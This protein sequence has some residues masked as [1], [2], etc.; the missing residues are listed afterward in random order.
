M[1]K[2]L[3]ITIGLFMTLLVSC[4][5]EDADFNNIITN[6]NE[7]EIPVNFSFSMKDAMEY[8]TDYVPMRAAAAEADEYPVK[9][10]ITNVCKVLFVK[11]ID[12]QWIVEKVLDFKIDPNGGYNN[13]IRDTTVFNFSTDL[14]PG[15][16]RVCV[17]TGFNS[18][19]WNSD[20]KPG[21]VVGT[22]DDN[23]SVPFVYKYRT[24]SAFLNVGF[25]QLSEEIFGGFT[26]FT[27]K[28]TEDLH[29][30]IENPVFLKLKRKVAKLRILLK[31]VNS[32][33]GNQSFF[34]SA[35]N[36]ITADLVSNSDTP[37]P[38]GLDVWG[39]PYYGNDTI[40][41]KMKF[42]TYTW[43]APQQGNNG[44]KYLLGM[45]RATNHFTPYYFSDPDK[46]IKISV[47]NVNNTESSDRHIRYLFTDT[48]KDIILKHNQTSGIVF[49]PG[50]N[51]DFDY[52][53]PNYG[54]MVRDM[55]LEKENDGK[56]VDATKIFD[57][58][59]EL[60]E[61]K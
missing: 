33:S 7:E 24:N 43:I 46:D 60:K 11:K 49:Y 50:D 37:F 22:V 2:Q 58:Y 23:T 10:I 9:S 32:P 48:V 57:L 15:E 26:D 59:Y 30:Y 25:Y 17:F 5:Q 28:K 1:L 54:D 52:D 55:I 41:T 39:N 3:I 29:S 20:L 56:P 21:K 45:K 51:E 27:V 19:S 47:T 40:I 44:T 42:G 35:P 53:S 18:V 38:S 16:Y 36:A 61:S 31:Y 34:A 12:T 4:Q 8:E 14:R 13:E 6:Q